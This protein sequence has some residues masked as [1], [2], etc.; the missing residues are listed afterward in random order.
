MINSPLDD[1]YYFA[2]VV[3]NE[4]FSAA[5]RVSGIPKSKLSRRISQLEEHLGVRLI[6]RNSRQ[7]AVTE[8][9]LKIYEQA[10]IMLNANKTAQ[11]IVQRQSEIPRG[12][13]R[14]SIPTTIAQNEIVHILPEFLKTYPEIQLQLF[15]HNRRFDVIHEN[16]DIALRVRNQLDE[17]QGLIIRHLNHEQLLC[18]ATPEYLTEYGTPK[19]PDDLQ[20]HR[21]L[22]INEH[23]VQ[24]ELEL[25]QNDQSSIKI[26][27]K[28][29]LVGGDF[30]F[31]SQLVKQ[32]CGIAFLPTS[33]CQKEIESGKLINILPE[34][35][36]PHGIFHLV[37]PSRKGILPAV[38][39]FIDFLVSKLSSADRE[40]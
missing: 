18:C 17:D 27:F 13:I 16:I 9:G 32:H 36:M 29:S 38:R 39:V 7:F 23:S 14:V 34:W 11:E 12:T 15:V 4:G 28:P 1:Y 19:L 6:Q 10:Q 31:L 30:I 35:H 37:Y 40:L 2:L 5:E 33:C 21:I 25:F 20:N 3:E 24:Q 8:M 22:S 26:K